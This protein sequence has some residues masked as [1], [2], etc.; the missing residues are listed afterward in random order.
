MSPELDRRLFSVD[1][2]GAAR[3]A[4]DGGPA[5]GRIRLVPAGPDVAAPGSLALETLHDAEVGSSS[6]VYRGRCGVGEAAAW[7]ALKVQRD[8]VISG[9]QSAAIVAKFQVEHAAYSLLRGSEAGARALLGLRAALRN[10]VLKRWEAEARPWNP[11]LKGIVEF[12]RKQWRTRVREG[13]KLWL[14]RA[15]EAAWVPFDRLDAALAPL[16]AGAT[17][18]APRPPRGPP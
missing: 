14:A 2:P 11:W 3:A 17:A 9:E 4:P 16:D 6:R 8:E 15:R 13:V 12:E 1:D 5:A 18:P 10:D 7:V